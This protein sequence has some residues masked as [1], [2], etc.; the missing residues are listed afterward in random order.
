ME[1]IDAFLSH[2]AA[3]RG[4]AEAT[5]AAYSRDLCQLGTQPTRG[6]MMSAFDAKQAS[7]ATNREAC[8]TRVWVVAPALDRTTT[9]S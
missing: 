7:R 5:L 8:R 9:A 3:E 4:V 2:L 1:Q 6:S